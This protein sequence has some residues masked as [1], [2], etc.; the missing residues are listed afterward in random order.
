M[1]TLMD[2][3]APALERVQ[4]LRIPGPAGEIPAR[5]YAPRAGQTP[6]DNMRY[7]GGRIDLVDAT[8]GP[9]DPSGHAYFVF[10]YEALTDLMWVLDGA[11]L[12]KRAAPDGTLVCNDWN[13]T[14]CASGGGRYSLK[15]APGRQPSLSRRALRA[16]WPL[17]LPFQ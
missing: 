14:S 5:A 8:L 16:I 3:P 6:L 17:L 10:A 1:V 15:V 9:G 13:G 4:D 2:E 11:S 12:A 7:A